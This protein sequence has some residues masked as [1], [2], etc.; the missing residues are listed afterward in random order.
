MQGRPLKSDLPSL[1]VSGQWH[2]LGGYTGISTWTRDTEYAIPF[3]IGQG[4]RVNGIGVR[5]EAAAVAGATAILA[6]REPGIADGTPGRVIESVVLD[7][8][9]TGF[10][11]DTTVDF[12]IPSSFVWL[13]ATFQGGAADPSIRH[14]NAPFPYPGV[15]SNP[16]SS[17]TSATVCCIM[18]DADRTTPGVLPDSFGNVNIRLD[19]FPFVYLRGA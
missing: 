17:P 19:Q 5:I 18:S 14:G 8:S 2:T 11:S 16:A 15:A 1:L 4:D 13:T 7:I 9:T 3:R 10:K 12:Y 6:V